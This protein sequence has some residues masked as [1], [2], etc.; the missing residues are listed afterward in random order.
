MLLQRNKIQIGNRQQI[1]L[2]ATIRGNKSQAE[3]G[4]K[5][6]FCSPMEIQANNESEDLI[7]AVG[8]I[9]KR[10]SD[11]RNLIAVSTL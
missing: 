3:F 2:A 8:M 4:N 11:R 10:E 1:Q 5:S 9:S 6:K 7:V